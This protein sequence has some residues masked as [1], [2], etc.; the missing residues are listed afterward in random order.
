MFLGRSQVFF[1]PSPPLP[2]EVASPDQPLVVP[3]PLLRRCRPLPLTKLFMADSGPTEIASD[4]E[5]PNATYSANPDGEDN[6]AEKDDTSVPHSQASKVSSDRKLSRLSSIIGVEKELPIATYGTIPDGEDNAVEEDDVPAPLSQAP[7]TPG[8]R[9]LLR[10]PSTGQRELRCKRDVKRGLPAREPPSPSPP[11]RKKKKVLTK[12]MPVWCTSR[13]LVPCETGLKL[14]T[15]SGASDLP[16]S[17][18]SGKRV[19]GYEA[20]DESE[21]PKR[22]V[23]A[24]ESVNYGVDTGCDKTGDVVEKEVSSSGL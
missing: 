21:K 24:V 8:D 11:V 22:K 1:P 7:K 15:A 19:R 5:L 4:V 3:S 16:T 17:S 20:D 9:K 23:R 14:G 2:A 10:L 12:K 6:S 13:A 18:P